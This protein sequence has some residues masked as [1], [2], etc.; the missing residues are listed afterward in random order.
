MLII[1]RSQFQ[2]CAAWPFTVA[3]TTNYLCCLVTYL[4]NAKLKGIVVARNR[5]APP[6]FLQ[7]YHRVSLD[8]KYPMFIAIVG[9]M[10]CRESI[11]F[12]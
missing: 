10:L 12:L 11:N 8:S 9:Q 5:V 6:L 3:L 4:K 2:S 1:F 7:P